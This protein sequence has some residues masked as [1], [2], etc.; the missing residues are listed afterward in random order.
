MDWVL[1][2]I[3]VLLVGI[4]STFVY[5]ST[6]ILPVIAILCSFLFPFYFVP[7]LFCYTLLCW[8]DGCEWK[9]GRPWASF[10]EKNP[11]FKMMRRYFPIKLHISAGLKPENMTGQEQFVFA[12]HPHGTCSDY[13]LIMDGM[14]SQCIPKLKSWRTLA[15]SILFK[16]PLIREL[17]IWTRCVDA[18]RKVAERVLFEGHSIMVIPG[19]EKEQLLT[20]YQ[21]EIVFLSSRK[22]FVRLAMKF[23]VPIVP[24]YVFGCSDLYKTSPAFLETRTFIMKKLRIGL[25]LFWGRRGFG[26]PLL[27]PHKIPLNVVFGEPIIIERKENPSQLEIDDAHSKYIHALIEIFEINKAKF[28]YADRSLCIQ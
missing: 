27:C 17:V 22:G 28:G 6:I 25:P 10:S 18:S 9:T 16:L 23:G 24:V 7:I 5:L 14:I 2:E 20:T 13:R 8:L 12:I 4:A 3:E 21:Q 15:A 19:G 11:F 26:V 1:D